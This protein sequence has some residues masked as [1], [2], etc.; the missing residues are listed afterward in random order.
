VCCT[1][2][3]PH[4]SMSTY[5]RKRLGSLSIHIPSTPDQYDRRLAGTGVRL[6]IIHEVCATS[7][8]RDRG[9]L[10]QTLHTQ[11][12][13]PCTHSMGVFQTSSQNV[14]QWLIN[15]ACSLGCGWSE[16]SSM[17]TAPCLES[18]ACRSPAAGTRPVETLQPGSGLV[19]H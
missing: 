13:C 5:S 19:D 17:A 6:G 15:S 10:P 3:S 8:S 1:E 16:P 12:H 4:Q 7:V 18:S 11:I 14:F 9:A 2:E